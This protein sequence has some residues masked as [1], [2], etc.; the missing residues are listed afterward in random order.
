MMRNKIQKIDEKFL[1]LYAQKLFIKLYKF[2][3]K[4]SHKI[5]YYK[6][7]VH[8]LQYFSEEDHNSDRHK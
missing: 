8:T 3:R 4:I 5:N 1:Y 6:I 2:T 7:L